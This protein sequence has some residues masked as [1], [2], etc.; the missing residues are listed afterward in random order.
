MI[1]ETEFV[2]IKCF[3]RTLRENTDYAQRI[4]N[5]KNAQLSAHST[6]IARLRSALAAETGTRRLAQLNA[7]IGARRLAQFLARQR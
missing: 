7:S 6:E 1:T 3:D 2:A 4:I 5:R